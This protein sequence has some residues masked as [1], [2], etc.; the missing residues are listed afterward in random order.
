MEAFTL[1][2]QRALLEF[3]RE[4]HAERD[5]AKMPG[6]LLDAID[7]VVP[8]EYSG[9]HEI[10]ARNVGL[11]IT[12]QKPNLVSPKDTPRFVHYLPEHPLFPIY[13]R[14]PGT[15][16][17][18]ISDIVTQ[19]QFRRTGL[20]SECYRAL[21][22]E[23]Q[24]AVPSPA[25]AG[26]FRVVALNRKRHDFSERER[27]LLAVVQPH[28]ALAY[29][30]AEALARLQRH[31]HMLRRALDESGLGVMLVDPK[32]RVRTRTESARL[33]TR[34]YLDQSSGSE[35]PTSL[36]AWTRSQL[37]AIDGNGS[38]HPNPLVVERGD[39]R[40][41]VRLLVDCDRGE[42]LL[43]MEEQQTTFRPSAY[44]AIGLGRREAEVLAWVARG[45]TN[46]ET[47]AILGLSPRTVQKHLEHIFEKLAVET[48]TAAV[49]RARDLISSTRL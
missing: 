40:L 20:Y 44:Q 42:H 5:L 9:F 27:R 47:A 3:F 33:L 35:L 2:D 10:D 28:A 48:R 23:H 31:V 8:S 4:I 6:A 1:R 13:A 15:A 41:V 19:R 45:K 38:P 7:R 25:R 11:G 30:N 32:G 36:L 21:G 18:K 49:A 24:I 17:L 39:E 26:F 12:A 16:P 46:D 14:S 29:R 37:A 22:A 34:K 43:L